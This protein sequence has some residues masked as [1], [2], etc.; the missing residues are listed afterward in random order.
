MERS[1]QR[2]GKFR[3]SIAQAAIAVGLVGAIMTSADATAKRARQTSVHRSPRAHHAP[4]AHRAPVPTPTPA[5]TPAPTPVITVVAPLVPTAPH[6]PAPVGGDLFPV[7]DLPAESCLVHA[8]TLGTTAA[9]AGMIDGRALK[10]PRALERLRRKTP[11]GTMFVDAIDLSGAKFAGLKLYDVCFLHG[12]LGLSDWSGFSGAGLGFIDS[13][14]TGAKFVGASMPSTLFR[15]VTLSQ[16]DATRADF[17]GSRLDGGWKGS[18]RDLKLDGAQLVGF[19]VECGVT[20]TDGCPVDRRGLSLKGANLRNASFYPFYFPDVDTTGAILDRTEIGLEHLARL[21][22]VKVVGPIIVRSRTSAAIFLPRELGLLRRALL[23]GGTDAASF[24]C[25]LARTVIQ[26]VICTTPGSELRRLDREVAGLERAVAD[27]ADRSAWLAQRDSCA[28]RAEDEIGE[29]LR[30]AYRARR[31]AMLTRTGAPTWLKPG[32]MAL[33]VSTDAPLTPEF[34]R[35]ELFT[36]IRPVILDT[37]Q[38]RAMIRV[39][40]DGQVE[41]KGAAL[42]GCLLRAGALGYDPATGWIT[43]GGVAATPRSPGIPGKPVLQAMGDGL[44]VYRDGVV[45]QGGTSPF[46]QCG[47]TGSFV[48]MQRVAIADDQLAELWASF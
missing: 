20:V 5:P 33:F 30:T 42:G 3:V 40:T 35:S 28:L 36:R 6:A 14:L 19:R 16:V 13:D 12:K 7:A 2:S 32:Q 11:V 43:A 1:G 44:R 41:A 38:A 45:S 22:G 21:R 48:P 26:R 29:C 15:D 47:P 37:A 34:L 18:M 25:T 46:V 10:T 39:A 8:P 24:D 23:S 17:S 9:P 4:R 27:A 31:D